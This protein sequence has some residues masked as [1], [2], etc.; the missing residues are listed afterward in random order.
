M[1]TAQP[2]A[3]PYHGDGMAFARNNLPGLQE[4]AARLT[5]HVDSAEREIGETR[6]ILQDAIARL[7]PAF[8]AGNG[9]AL[10]TTGRATALAKRRSA[11]ASSALSAL[12]FQDISDQLLAHAQMRLTSLRTEVDDIA[13]T[14]ADEPEA[15][16]FETIMQAVQKVNRNLAALESSLV[17]PVGTPHLGTGNMEVF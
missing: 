17:K 7:M 4:L 8:M 15:T 13:R 11:A 2:T 9:D 3:I 10:S 16:N 6:A 12:Q 1:S 14:L 5:A